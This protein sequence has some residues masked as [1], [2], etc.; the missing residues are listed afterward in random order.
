MNTHTIQQTAAHF[1]AQH[2][3]DIQSA[4]KLIEIVIRHAHTVQVAR[5][6]AADPQLELPIELADNAR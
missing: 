3:Y 6:K 4:L 5:I 2:D 1:N